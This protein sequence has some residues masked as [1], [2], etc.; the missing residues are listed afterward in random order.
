[1]RHRRTTRF[2]KPGAHTWIVAVVLS[3]CAGSVPL[4]TPISRIETLGNT[5][6]P[7]PNGDWRL[8]ASRTVSGGGTLGGGTSNQHSVEAFYAKIEGSELMG[9]VYVS[10]SADAPSSGGYAT[11]NGCIKPANLDYVYYNE[12]S[13]MTV[14][15]TDC[16]VVRGNRVMNRPGAS[17]TEL[18][19]AAYEKAK[20]FGGVPRQAVEASFAEAHNFRFL[21]YT[22]W[23]FPE[24]ARVP[25]NNVSW[26][27]DDLAPPTRKFVDGIVDWAKRFRVAVKRGTEYRL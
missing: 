3:G 13:G 19:R 26:R 4:E 17:S 25:V 5:Q 12:V 2:L 10:T 8:L 23:F 1:M 20:E 18:Y 15:S 14:N 22:A 7:F 16:T 21:N 11:G 6:V 27:S 9:L 24:R